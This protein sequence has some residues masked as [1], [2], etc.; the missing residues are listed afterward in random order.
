MST[1]NEVSD[2]K[3]GSAEDQLLEHQYDGIQEYD[4]PMPGWWVWMFWGSFIFSC[5]YIFH[6]WIG[7]GESEIHTYEGEMVI[8][9][10]LAAKQAMEQSVSEES[11]A[12]VLADEGSLKAG[13]EV[14]QARCA[15][16]HLDQGQGLIGANLTDRHW[17]HGKGELMD[18]YK[19]VSDG[20]LEKG[21]PAWSRQLTP[22]EL[23]QV[24]AF[25]G[26]LR[27]KNV[28]GKAAEGQLVE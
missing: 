28:P 1:A 2:K 6:Y 7:N 3:E 12:Q 5:G 25:T 22:V 21:M 11:L 13:N 20:V 17:I 14:F 4:N 26:S 10:E 16:C 27:G 23:R 8:A 15:A 24:V 9:R 19:T 18:I